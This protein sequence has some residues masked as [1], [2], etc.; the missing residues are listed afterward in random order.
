[1]G[2]VAPCKCGPVAPRANATG[3]ERG[4]QHNYALHGRPGRPTAKPG[5]CERLIML[6]TGALAT[7][8]DGYQKNSFEY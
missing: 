3:P 5:P 7:V 4:H 1:M 2:E 6:W 8:K